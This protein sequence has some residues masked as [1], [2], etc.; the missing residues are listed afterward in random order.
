MSK[1]AKGKPWHSKEGKVYH[2]NSMCAEGKK[3]LKR[4]EGPGQKPHCQKC[5]RLNNQP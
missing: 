1:K 5:G 4:L 2:D 3:I